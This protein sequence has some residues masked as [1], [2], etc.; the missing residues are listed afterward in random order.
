MHT[1]ITD[2]G[3]AHLKGLNNLSRLRLGD[4]F[5]AAGLRVEESLKPLFDLPPITDAGL[6]HLEG[7]TNLSELDLSGNEIT[8]AGLVHLKALA[9]LRI[10]D[11]RGTRV[12][13]AGAKDLQ[14]ALPRLKII[15]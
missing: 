4:A 8:D 10:V 2:A 9:N 14:R 12:T 1:R 13:D 3:L 7:L 6:A 15:R 5:I 11:L